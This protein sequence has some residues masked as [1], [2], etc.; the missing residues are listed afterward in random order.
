MT[1]TNTRSSVSV[2]LF[3]VIGLATVIA[4][5]TFFSSGGFFRDKQRAVLHFNSSLSGL[6]V[7]APVTFRGV[8]VGNVEGIELRIDGA[9][10]EA[11]I[12][13]RISLDP[14]AAQWG[15][16][17]D[18]MP[19]IAELVGRG[20]RAQLGSQ[21]FVT[22]QLYVELDFYPDAERVPW[23]YA[24]DRD[25]I[26]PE[27]PTMASD[28]A[29][30][31]DFLRELP[32]EQ[33]VDSLSDTLLGINRMVNMLEQQLPAIG[34]GITATTEALQTSIPQLTEDFGRMRADF[35]RFTAQSNESVGRFTTTADAIS[36]D[37]A[38]LSA[39]MTETSET[40]RATALQLES[41]IAEDAPVRADLEQMTYDLR[42]SARAL[43]NLTELLEDKPSSLIFGR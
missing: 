16:Q 7:G 36:A 22:G 19:D 31:L 33:I 23:V 32:A 26:H 41:L 4:G 10:A 20:L 8:R 42:R 9:Q 2:G 37:F 28:A 12:P 5:I 17:P 38:A 18:A 3:F 24:S 25:S 15:G 27:I 30:L 29:Q 1:S 34:E 35:A 39:D 14:E 21:S 43:R 13:V 6:N 40:L 11:R